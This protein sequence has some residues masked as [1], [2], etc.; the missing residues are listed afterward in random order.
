MQRL[1][2]SFLGTVVVYVKRYLFHFQILLVRSQSADLIANNVT[3]YCG[4]KTSP[5]VA[6]LEILLTSYVSIN[7]N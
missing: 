4:L 1:Y 6:K 7:Q 5:D 2:R 3:R